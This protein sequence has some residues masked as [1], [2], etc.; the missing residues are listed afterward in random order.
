MSRV[1]GRLASRTSPSVFA[2]TFRILRRPREVGGLQGGCWAV[3]GPGNEAR[4]ELHTQ[5]APCSIVVESV[6]D[7][8]GVGAVIDEV[9]ARTVG[10]DG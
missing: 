6:H 5:G 7:V 2:F 4:P 10:S 9:H 1:R 8:E 3:A